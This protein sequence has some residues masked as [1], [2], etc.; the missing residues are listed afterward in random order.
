MGR[1]YLELGDCETAISYGRKAIG[2]ALKCENSSW[3]MYSVILVGECEVCMGHLDKAFKSFKIALDCAYRIGD[4]KSATIIRSAV[5]KIQKQIE[6][7]LNSNKLPIMEGKSKGKILLPKGKIMDNKEFQKFSD[8]TLDIIFILLDKLFKEFFLIK[9]EKNIIPT[10]FVKE[11]VT[12]IEQVAQF[13]NVYRKHKFFTDMANSLGEFIRKHAQDMLQKGTGKLTDYVFGII[14]GIIN[15]IKDVQIDDEIN[16][17]QLKKL[18]IETISAAL[19]ST[20]Q[21]VNTHRKQEISNK[22]YR[23]LLSLSKPD[24]RPMQ[25]RLL[26]MAEYND[27]INSTALD[28]VEEIFQEVNVTLHEP[29]AFD[30]ILHGFSIISDVLK[31]VMKQMEEVSDPLISQM[32]E[33]PGSSDL[34]KTLLLKIVKNMPKD[35]ML[36]DVPNN[37]QNCFDKFSKLVVNGFPEIVN[38][39][40]NCSD[41]ETYGLISQ[42]V[43]N[44]MADFILRD[45][46]S[47][48]S[49]IDRKTSN[50]N[51]QNCFMK[52]ICKILI[53]KTID[54]LWNNFEIESDNVQ[55]E[56]YRDLSFKIF[57]EIDKCLYSI[58]SI[59][60]ADEK[61]LT[62]IV[63]DFTTD[64]L[65]EVLRVVKEDNVKGTQVSIIKHSNALQIISSAIINNILERV[66]Q[67]L[68]T[69]E[70]LFNENAI[71]IGQDIIYKLLL[72]SASKL[73]KLTDI[74]EESKDLKFHSTLKKALTMWKKSVRREL[75]ACSKDTEQMLVTEKDLSSKLKTSDEA[76]K[77][78]KSDALK[79]KKS[80]DKPT[81]RKISSYLV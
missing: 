12:Y 41:A 27:C 66:R 45:V 59:C 36:K 52:E 17:Q 70:K 64:T 56:I 28:I 73:G 3:N 7:E 33:N 1:C 80:L 42:E 68:I 23:N 24:S 5:R 65:Q 74:E 77:K 34:A 2:A 30:L 75:S 18:G 4:Q 79:P 50:V 49:K 63:L 37:I 29:N 81:V 10:D 22:I 9:K 38:Q 44:N 78:R 11:M 46:C 62:E 69:D 13:R 39:I 20:I 47:N 48:L 61:D 16:F 71:R 21:G 15:D 58:K 35:Q 53:F 43:A 6:L 57:H 19:A 26:G 54:E 8:V 40:I 72:Q 14:A 76:T 51:D 67:D 25:T 55:A 60:P 31:N 32:E